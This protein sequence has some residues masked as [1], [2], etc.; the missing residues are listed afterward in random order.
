MANKPEIP[1]MSGSESKKEKKG[2]KKENKKEV[3]RPGLLRRKLDDAFGSFVGAKGRWEKELA[4]LDATEPKENKKE[5]KK[6]DKEKAVKRPG[7]LHRKLDDNF[8]SL[9]NSSSRWEKELAYLD[10]TEPK[11]KKDEKESVKE[12]ADAT[13]AVEE[14]TTEVASEIDKASAK[15]AKEVEDLKTEVAGDSELEAE[16]FEIAGEAQAN[17]AEAKVII[18]PE[19]VEEMRVME[20]QKNKIKEVLKNAGIKLEDGDEEVIA[21]SIREKIHDWNVADSQDYY[22]DSKQIEE[23][24]RQVQS[25]GQVKNSVGESDLGTSVEEPTIEAKV[26]EEKKDEPVVESETKQESAS[27][28]NVDGAVG[29]VVEN[30]EFPDI[31]KEQMQQIKD[32]IKREFPKDEDISENMAEK[33]K[34]IIHEQNEKDATDYFGNVEKTVDAYHQVLESEHPVVA[35]QVKQISE[36]LNIGDEKVSNKTIHDVRRKI[37]DWNVIDAKNHFEDP[38]QIKEAYKQVKET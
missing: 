14:V 8:G 36:L 30:K 2:D 34:G 13:K 28:D 38:D 9:F 20:E 4:Y 11:E 12:N 16:V 27:T 29:N 15:T 32:I 7:L 17:T 25:E 6:S 26:P 10:A 5:V 31:E 33:I 24:Y 18:H 23:A 19:V 35:E 3:K 21:E 37:N 22:V 1:Q